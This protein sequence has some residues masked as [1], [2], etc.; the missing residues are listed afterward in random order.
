MRSTSS[1]IGAAL[2]LAAAALL[3]PALAGQEARLLTR[4]G[5]EIDPAAVHPEHPRPQFRR[6][7]WQNLNGTWQHAITPR[8]AG[9]PDTWAGPILVPFPVESRLS[10]VQQRVGAEQRLWYRRSFRVPAGWDGQRVLLHFGAVDWQAEVWVDGEAVGSHEGGYDPFRFDLGP[11]DPAAEH[12]L[13][14]AVWD[15]TDEGTQPRGKQVRQPGGIWYT[16]TTGIW[17][18]VW[19]EAVPESSIGGAKLVGSFLNSRLELE[20]RIDGPAEGL[21]LEARA[22]LD[23]DEV[24]VASAAPRYGTVKL[25]LAIP[26]PR[27]WSPDSPTLYDLDLV[28][29][30]GD[31]VVDRVASYFGLRDIALGHD[32]AGVPRLLLN[33][34]PLFQYGPLD[35]GF[36][37]DGLYTAPSDEALRYDLE[38]T[39]Q[40]GFNMVRKHVKIESDR[41]YSW[42]DRMGLLVWQDMPSGDRYIGPADPDI[43]RSPESSAG[44][45][46]EHRELVEDF[47]N[48]PSIVMWVPFNEGW[49]QFETARV[50]DWLRVLDPSRLVNSVS[51]WADRGV[52]DVYDFHV[53][54]GP[55]MPPLEARRTAVLGEFGGLGLP[56][57][58]HTWQDE[59]NW[60]Y[61]SYEDAGALTEAYLQLIERLRPLVH[62]GLCAAVYTQTTDVEVEV[63]G[64]M[65]YD[66]AVI[67]MDPAV[68]RAANLR[69]YE[70]PPVVETV[71]ESS[72]RT[73]QTWSWT[74]AA[75]AA[76][77]EQPDFD[78]SAWSRGPGGFGTAGTP[79]A[80]VATE[81]SGP[82]IWLRRS[83]PWKGE[84]PEGELYLRVHHDE[85]AEVWLNGTRVAE[86]E[87]YT[88][89]YTLVALGPEARGLLRQGVN[90]LAV[91]CRQTGGGQ[92][93]DLGLEMVRERGEDGAR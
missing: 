81:W 13:V 84:L 22:V 25:T 42:C 5:A 83:F 67:K 17:Q 10:G 43:E 45:F 56:L 90:T 30:R 49:G 74:T 47:G 87:G 51:G 55:G 12:E 70:P 80:V 28:L 75:P 77:W 82:E 58:G 85:D 6:E 93:I 29:L 31:E 1:L 78:A 57:P 91:H 79:G 37:P 41:W 46:R 64:L 20:A 72:R 7:A 24:A 52:G 54:P 36:W 19:I 11:L 59:K 14:V 65:S 26:E 2:G 62:E 9:R 63:N 61:R 38:V 16:P 39:K 68:V 50:V 21:R 23:G 73:A 71:L 76:G 86:L 34:E 3:A 32:S 15:P 88:T 92:Y 60:G 89:S 69:L 53:Y 8:Q 44:F 4:W 27:A 66:R 18:T 48:H 40:L 35:Q 33:G